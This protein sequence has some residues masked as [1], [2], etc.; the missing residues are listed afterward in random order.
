[1][2]GASRVVRALR[3][4]AHPVAVQNFF[5]NPNPDLYLDEKEKWSL[6]PRDWLLSGGDPGVLAPLAEL[7]P[8]DRRGSVHCCSQYVTRPP[9]LH[10]QRTPPSW[11][12]TTATAP[13]STPH[14][15]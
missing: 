4:G 8:L 12:T 11:E 2:P 1:M 13:G 10:A 3:Q 6:S 15:R 5:T 7:C 14:K 9:F